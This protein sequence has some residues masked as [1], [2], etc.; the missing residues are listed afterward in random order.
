M[1]GMMAFLV[2]VGGVSMICYW[3][4]RRAENRAARRSRDASGGDYSF[5]SSSIG[6]WSFASWFSSNNSSSDSSATSSASGSWDSGGSDGGGGGGD[7]G[8]D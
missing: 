4:M 3:L 5:D 7:G 6:G 2:A 8:G 1:G